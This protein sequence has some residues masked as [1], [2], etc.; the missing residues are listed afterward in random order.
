MSAVTPTQKKA[1]SSKSAVKIEARD[2]VQKT[3]AKA[4]K[5]EKNSKST[6]STVKIKPKDINRQSK[7][8]GM[9][10]KVLKKKNQEILDEIMKNT[11]TDPRWNAVTPV[12]A[13]ESPAN[14]E[15]P[16]PI[17]ADIELNVESRKIIESAEPEF[18][19][20]LVKKQFS[21]GAAADKSQQNVPVKLRTRRVSV[22]KSS[23]TKAEVHGHRP[24]ELQKV[25]STTSKSGPRPVVGQKVDGRNVVRKHIGSLVRKLPTYSKRMD[26]A[27]H[28]SSRV[29]F[30]VRK[31]RRKLF[32]SESTELSSRQSAG[33][34]AAGLG[35]AE[36]KSQDAAA[37]KMRRQQKPAVTKSSDVKTVARRRRAE[38]RKARLSEVRISRESHVNEPDHTKL[39]IRTVRAK[40]LDFARRFCCFGKD[41]HL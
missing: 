7:T 15:S 41:S 39:N 6:E 18:P 17:R 14:G 26:L 28:Q 3:E 19:P 5:I 16:Q 20:D 10:A 34:K 40:Q 37:A 2:D 25:V 12:N 4:A 23:G 35:T 1:N 36:D 9:S 29:G 30:A 32:N 13:G 21:S 8:P 22:R 27:S 11:F 24:E 33:A 31:S 38:T